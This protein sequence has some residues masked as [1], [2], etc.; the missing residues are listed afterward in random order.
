MLF[1]LSLFTSL[2][3][4]TSSYTEDEPLDCIKRYLE[5]ISDG[6]ADKQMMVIT[7][8]YDFECKDRILLLQP[9]F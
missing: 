8:E 7:T 3:S 6:L 2:V 5:N 4:V 9:I 1:L